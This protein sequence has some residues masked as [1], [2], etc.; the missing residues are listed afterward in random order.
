[1][2]SGV[3]SSSLSPTST[4]SRINSFPLQC[5]EQRKLDTPP[6]Y[7]GPMFKRNGAGYTETSKG[8]VGT[9]I[10]RIYG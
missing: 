10:G 1:M 3:P 6:F 2:A 7:F 4:V 5:I 9:E 8:I